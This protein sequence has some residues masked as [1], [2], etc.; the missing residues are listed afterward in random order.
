MALSWVEIQERAKVFA[1]KWKATKG[2][3]EAHAQTFLRDFFNVF[4]AVD[5]LDNA[6]EFEH[7]VKVDD[8]R[9]G[10]IDCFW[11]KRIAIEM[12]S[13]GKNLEDAYEQAKNYVVHLP[14]E[15]IPELV[16]VSDFDNIILYRRVT[17]EKTAIKLENLAKHVK[18]FAILA[19]YEAT[20]TYDAQIEL[21]VKAAEKMAKLHDALKATGYEGHPLEVYLVRLLFCLFA[22]D[23]DIFPKDGFHAYVDNA[24]AD[25][26]D[27]SLRIHKLFE[28]L[29]L[30]PEERAKKKLLSDDLKQF[31][32]VNGGL[33]NAPLPT[34]D[35]DANMRKI[36]L[37]C[38][39]FDWSRISPA[40]FGAMF[41]GVMDKDKRREIGAHY[42]SEENILKLINPLFMDEL[43]A[44][45]EADKAYSKR[46]EKLHEKISRLKFLDPACG[47]GNFLIVAYRELR[48]LELNILK[49]QAKTR[50]L[51]LDISSLLKVNIGQFY[52]IEI[53]D[54]PCEVARVGMWLMEHQMN[55][56]FGKEFGVSY[57][58]LPL[59]ESANITHGNALTMDWKSIVAKKELSY[60]MGNPPFVGKKEQSKEQKSDLFSVFEGKK[61]VGILDYVAAWY[62]K[63]ANMLNDTAIRTAFVSTNSISQGEQPAI[64]WENLTNSIKIDF[65]YRTFKWSNEA[66]GKAAVHCVIIGFSSKSIHTTPML[67]EDG[68]MTQAENINPYLV[69]APDVL[70]KNRTSQICNVPRI[71]YG[72]MPIDNGALIL[73]DEEKQDL[74]KTESQSTKFLRRYIGGHELI[75]NTI[76]WCIWLKG[77]SSTEIRHSEYIMARIHQCR[78]FRSS[79]NRPQTLALADTPYLFGEIRQPDT[80]M[81]VIPKVSSEKRK[82]LPIGF[83]EPSVIVN[84]S[85]LIIPAANLFHF[86]IMSSGVHNAWMRA[87]CGRLEMRYQY[88][89]GIVYNNFPWCD[90][91]DIQKEK[92]ETAAQAVL[93]ARAL[94]PES[95]LADLY[96]PLTMPLELQKAHQALDKAVLQA[97]GFSSKEFT[98]ANCVAHLMK[99]YQAL[100][101]GA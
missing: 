89:G 54:F 60:I 51:H 32:Y 53:E 18:K 82:Y 31:G 94:F 59:K 99:R 87:V 74:E 66:R 57:I 67:Y 34:A 17:G 33:F 3:E 84:G 37:D 91:T 85:A 62:K 20:K 49:M 64:L 10:Y 6:D 26:S 4:G 58:R 88:S 75:N 11:K 28:T 39:D 65:A 78:E 2:R 41:Q 97:Y 12:K 77:F 69:N 100:V 95:S 22:D 76:R 8:G 24:R 19:G 50:Q 86:G 21:N 90:A 52:G 35:F 7:K 27:L 72:S 43:R 46:L 48:L 47:C 80:R 36:L 16:M 23:T 71:F 30:S 45:F 44:E 81:L 68:S 15:E 96:D 83:V 93:D 56:L 79:S 40:I 14:A 13:R 98:E 38:C 25:G 5:V 29:N 9:N 63:S 42:T 70:I 73:S 61:G 55:Q 92:I 1:G 101:G